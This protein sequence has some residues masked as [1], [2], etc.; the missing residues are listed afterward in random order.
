MEDYY[1]LVTM[2]EIK[3]RNNRRKNTNS[4]LG[5]KSPVTAAICFIGLVLTVS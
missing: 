2:E 3:K 1:K 5:Q 4:S